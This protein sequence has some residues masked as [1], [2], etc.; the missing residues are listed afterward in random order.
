MST[1][2]QRVDQRLLL[3]RSAWRKYRSPDVFDS[4]ADQTAPPA[5]SIALSREAYALGSEI[6]ATLAKR[7]GWP[8]YDKEILELIAKDAHLQAELS[9]SVDERDRSVVEEIFSSL[10]GPYEMSSAGYAVHLKRVLAALSAIGGCVIV[11]RG[12]A[13]YLPAERTLRVRI[14]GDRADCA[15][16]YAAEHGVP[17][18][19]AEQRIDEL[20]ADR[21]RF[22]ANH[23]HQDVTNLH[24][25]DLALN[26]SRFTCDR[27]A[28][29]IEV[30]LGFKQADAKLVK[31]LQAK[32]ALSGKL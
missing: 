16:R 2:L 22:V 31:K 1:Q 29:L 25:F 28:E 10:M 12:A 19:L 11:G 20:N 24:Q 30:A 5:W 6:G 15:A 17:K 13:A 18:L 7:L 3:S 23:F 27:C 32:P 26:S 21:K 14:V 4:P 9:E 8:V